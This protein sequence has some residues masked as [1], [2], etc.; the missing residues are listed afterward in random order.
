MRLTV[1]G[2]GYLGA[3]HAAAMA[4]LGH[5][6]LGIETDPARLERLAQGESPFYEPGLDELLRRGAQEGR[7][8]YADG[9]SPAELAGAAV[10]FLAV[11]TPQSSSGH[12]TELG[13]LWE[14]V[15]A[16]VAALPR[17]RHLA[18]L[19]LVVGKSTVPVGTAARVADRLA[20][21]AL[22]VWNPEFLRE[23]T[24]VADTLRPDR[25][26]YGLPA[27]AAQAARARALLDE[28]YIELLVAGVPRLE[29]DYQTAELVKTAANSFLATKISFINAMS[30]MC[31]ATGA[32]VTVL[33]DAIGRDERI[34]GQFLRAGIGFG[35]GCL[36]KDLRG[37]RERAAELG[38]TELASFLDGVDS[39]NRGQRD[40][41]TRMALDALGSDPAGRTVTVLGIT[42]KPG[43]D[44]LR[45][46][47][48]LEVA[49][50]LADAGA[51]VVVHD[52]KGLPALPDL[53]PALRAQPSMLEALEG[54][55]LVVLGTEWAELT[56]L[57]PRVA[58]RRV[59]RRVIID[60]RNALVPAQWTEAGWDYRGIGRSRSPQRRRTPTTRPCVG[61][62]VG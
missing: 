55:D 10:H 9:P 8:R 44:D 45:D 22:V 20:G 30:S 11:G 3:V 36:P 19:P 37:L 5:H 60:A 50:R 14:A 41:V 1:I 13:Y 54:A 34:G 40:S 58:A 2:C 28:V 6:V 48:A 52:P 53:H 18:E 59:A 32:D 33:A 16:L 38:V 24:A 39:I 4:E 43:S 25:L 49:L 26:V 17:R 23:G 57:D 47:P 35:G 15:D 21:R 31:A 7:L 27:R 51:D 61:T 46:S 62:M 29:M 56:A 42:F 12:G